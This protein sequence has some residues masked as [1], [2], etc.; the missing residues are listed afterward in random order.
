MVLRDVC[1]QL[2]RDFNQVQW[3]APVVSEPS[4]RPSPSTPTPTP[5]AS[6]SPKLSAPPS[7]LPLHLHSNTS[8]A[9]AGRCS[10]RAIFC[11]HRSGE[12]VA[13]RMPV[14]PPASRAASK[15]PGCGWREHATQPAGRPEGRPGITKLRNRP[16]RSLPPPS[17]RMRAASCHRQSSPLA[18]ARSFALC[19]LLGAGRILPKVAGAGFRVFCCCCCAGGFYL[20]TDPG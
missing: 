20:R 14:T 12:E 11:N 15:K 16:P 6:F 10:P 7:A 2:L 9:K 13:A 17:P 4:H 5:A 1:D 8:L 19:L 3:K 18:L